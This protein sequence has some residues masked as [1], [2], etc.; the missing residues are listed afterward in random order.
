MRHARLPSP[1]RPVLRAFLALLLA[2]ALPAAAQVRTA[3]P[4]EAQAD[5]AAFAEVDQVLRQRLTDIDSVVVVQRGRIVYTFYRDDAPDK[6]RDVQSVEKSALSAL[7]GIALAQGRI[8]SLD[9]RVVELVPEWAPLNADARAGAITLRHLLTMT[10]GFDTR[11]APPHGGKL[12]PPRAW[13]RPLAADPGSTFA[14]DNSIVA[15]IGAVL[16]KA[17]GMAVAE[18]AR[19][20]LVAPLAM[21]EP[22]YRQVVH[23]RT[24]DIARLGQLFLQD[25]AWDGQQ[26]LPAGFVAAATQPQNAG[27][28]P[29]SLPYGFLW[30]VLPGEG[31]RR[32]FLASGY[33]GQ[34]VWVHPALELVVAA[35]SPV[36]PQSQQRGQTAQLLRSGLVAAAEKRSREAPR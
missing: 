27:G 11:G 6:L 20:H 21:A 19:R 9:Q 15:V 7:V 32:T 17:T 34:M 3:T 14:Y 18:F 31:P 26:L 23:L 1:A 24:V 5:A 36:S 4:E 12:A 33:G 10:A 16:E 13:A 22:A 29:A 8:A 25:G 35:T 2:A 30:W 28:P